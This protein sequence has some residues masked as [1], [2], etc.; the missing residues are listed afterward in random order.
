ML[1]AIKHDPHRNREVK[2]FAL[3]GHFDHV[4]VFDNVDAWVCPVNTPFMED[5]RRILG[6][7]RAGTFKGALMPRR[8][9]RTAALQMSIPE[10]VPAD[11]TQPSAPRRERR[12]AAATTTTTTAPRRER[13]AARV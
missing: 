3:P 2:V 7:V 10:L 12:V 6:E 8:P 9:R 5:V 1:L 11:Q 4:G 13:R